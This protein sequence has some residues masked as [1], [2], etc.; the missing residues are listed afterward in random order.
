MRL[1]SK[2]LTGAAPFGG[3]ASEEKMQNAYNKDKRWAEILEQILKK[4]NG[5]IC[6]SAKQAA[7][8]MNVAR[9]TL[10][11]RHTHGTLAIQ[12]IEA[13]RPRLFFNAFVIADVLAEV[14]ERPRPRRGPPLKEE[15]IAAHAA[16]MSVTEFREH[17]KSVA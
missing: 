12:P 8:I 11:N 9:Q 16:G 10:Y 1:A 6:L 14:A 2:R 13:F 7:N 15:R 3:A 5:C 17:K 4:S